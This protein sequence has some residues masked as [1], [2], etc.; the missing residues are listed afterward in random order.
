MVWEYSISPESIIL[1]LYAALGKLSTLIFVTEKM[2]R[3]MA[4][5]SHTAN[6]VGAGGINTFKTIRL[7][8]QSAVILWF[9][10]NFARPICVTVALGGAFWGKPA[11]KATNL[12][13][14]Q[15]SYCDKY[16]LLLLAVQNRLEHQN[17]IKNHIKVPRLQWLKSLEKMLVRKKKQQELTQGF[18]TLINNTC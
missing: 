17:H 12:G 5:W 7:M 6:L 16:F 2:F 13:C 1:W 4:S 8:V 15:H 11:L 10:F 9:F 18:L 14:K 3:Y